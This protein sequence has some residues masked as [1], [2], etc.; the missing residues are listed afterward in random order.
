MQ[1]DLLRA[2][3]KVDLLLARAEAN[4]ELAAAPRPLLLAAVRRTL[5][6]LRR[7]I[8][9]GQAAATPD[10][11]TL[12]QAVGAALEAEMAFSLRPVVNATGIVLHTNLGRAALSAAAAGRAAEIAAAYS[13]LEY[14]AQ[15]GERGSRQTHAAGLL[16]RLTGA[17]A[18]L[19]V[20]NNAAALLLIMAA[21]CGGREA[22][23]SRGELV[24]IGDSF[25][26]PE[27]LRQGGVILREVGATNRTR[28]TDYAEAFNPERTGALLKVHPSNFRLVGYAGRPTTAEL[29]ALAAGYGLPLVYDLGSGALAD[30]EELKITDEPT[31]P[32]VLAEGAYLVCFSGDKL[33]GGPQAGLIVGRADLVARLKTHPLARA[34]RIDKLTLAALE[35]TLRL[36]LDPERARREIPTL[37]QL[38]APP[39]ELKA[40][41][42][43]LRQRLAAADPALELE[44][45]AV[46][47]QAGGGAIPEH[48]LPSWAVAAAHPHLAA[49]HLEAALRRRH[50]P[51]V[52]R[53]NHGR[54]LLDVRALQPGQAGLIAEAFSALTRPA[55]LC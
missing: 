25:R 4:P 34:L 17:Q 38:F 48:P 6:D 23:V 19:A 49:E 13:T 30:L 15:A 43:D 14:D 44:V 45:T 33:L 40:R 27:I 50:V 37:A 28:L 18:A 29:A 21:V 11:E 39:A 9:A 53:L 3:P 5:D 32:Q 22:I 10:Q 47:G 12:L 1:T 42:E 2:I 16:T 52:A 54:L 41:A 51:I 36:Y 26:L 24:E 46:E 8:L 7:N 55:D 35:V 31:V 20:N